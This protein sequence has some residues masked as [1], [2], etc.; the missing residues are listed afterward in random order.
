MDTK[1]SI[2]T[3]ALLVVAVVLSFAVGFHLG[4][5]GS[6]ENI[7]NEDEVDP[8]FTRYIHA[9][10]ITE[11]VGSAV[12]MNSTNERLRNHGLLQNVIDEAAMNPNRSQAGSVRHDASIDISKDEE[13]NMSDVLRGVP[14]YEKPVRGHYIRHEGEILN[15]D[16]TVLANSTAT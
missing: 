12:A 7:R 13:E 10:M 1:K 6:P 3:V 11:R 4:Q 2:A 16:I 8:V 5:T 14:Y 9:D 15:V